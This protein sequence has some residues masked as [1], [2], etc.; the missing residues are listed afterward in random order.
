MNRLGRYLVPFAAA[1]MLGGCGVQESFKEAD[2]EVGQFHTALNA[3][4]WQ[5]VWQ[6][7][8]PQLRQATTREQF[9]KLLDA[10]HRKLGKVTASKQTGWNANS[11]TGGTYVT[12]TMQTQFERG[13]GTEQ[14]VYHKG[15]DGKVALS[16]YNIQ[17]Q[18]MMLN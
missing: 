2:V 18:D 14:L 5:G 17:S 6:T 12:V 8:D 16:G 15:S 10:V 9:G 1:A 4:N 7:A 3:G 13:T 11:G